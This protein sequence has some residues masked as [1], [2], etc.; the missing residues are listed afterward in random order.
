MESVEPEKAELD[1]MAG[2]PRD[3]KTSADAVK[4]LNAKYGETSPGAGNG[5][6]IQDHIPL[7]ERRG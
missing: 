3:G 2:K 7:G 6:V 5:W 4:A 1:A